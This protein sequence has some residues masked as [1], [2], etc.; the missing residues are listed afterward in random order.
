MPLYD[1]DMVN[2]L[3]PD[4][5]AVSMPSGLAGMFPGLAPAPAIPD[6]AGP[7]GA[8]ADQAA[9]PAPDVP[10]LALPPPPAPPAGAPA[11]P[12]GPQEGP[13]TDPSQLATP[14][15]PARPQGPVTTPAEDTGTPRQPA[16]APVPTNQQ[17]AKN[18]AGRAVQES[19]RASDEERAGVI[20][21]ARVQAD[22][23]TREGARLAQRDA[24]TDR[25]LQERA[26]QAAANEAELNARIQARDQLADQI[27]KTRIDRSVDHPIWSQIGLV[28]SM[29]GTA[30]TR[31]PGEAF[32]DPAYNTLM[33]LIDRKVQGQVQDLD[34]KRQALA[35]M[36]VGVQEQRQHNLDRLTE[37][38]ARRDAAL[39]QAKQAV[40]TIAT[41]MKAPAAIAGAQQ[42][43]GK[44]DQERAKLHAEFGQKAQDQINVDA[45]RS[46][47]LQMHRETLGMQY[48]I[49]SETMAANERDKMAALAE[50]LMEKGD[51]KAAQRAKD[52][53]ER[54]VWDPRTADVQLNPTGQAK[55]QQA[56]QYEAA[57][58]QAQDPQQA[59]KLRQAASDLRDSARLND[60]VL[61]PDKATAEKVR[62]QL[63]AAQ[64]MIDQ[65]SEASKVLEAGPS[66]FNREAWAGLKTTLGDLA[67]NYAVMAGEKVT[68]KGIENAME[69]IVS[70][71]P[72]SWYHREVNKGKALAALASLKNIVRQ[73]AD[74]TLKGNGIKSNWLPVPKGEGENAT[75][76]DLSEK[77]ASE[78]G[79]DETLGY[80][81]HL[82][83]GVLGAGEAEER[84][85]NE[86]H[87]AAAM[88]PGAEAGLPPRAVTHIK[89]LAAKASTAGDSAYG[90]IVNSLSNVVAD[91]LRDDSRVPA[92]LGVIDV[93]GSAN[94]ALRDA[95]IAALPDMARERVRRLESARRPVTNVPRVPSK[96]DPDEAAA[97]ADAAAQAGRDTTQRY[98]DR[99]GRGATR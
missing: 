4:G 30:M 67:K 17:L 9:P 54:A 65:I 55:M 27:A 2:L 79:E 68:V 7:A 59:A 84:L 96:F 18:Y 61:A 3:T 63:Q 44:L 20:A 81:G 80:L 26:K 16:P 5:R 1:G 74:R 22:E 40:E 50:R 76:L 15:G 82:Q 42:L 89:A 88:A 77:T 93:L 11:A 58:R 83:A 41:Q 94:P 49:H 64:G 70:F 6:V 53:A 75:R 78:R 56:D 47:A 8:S 57:A 33:Q 90:E 29:L 62:P 25:L 99:A 71:D 43:L 39:Q 37:I 23:A 24:E 97:E 72:D 48:R 73:Q 46:Q 36:N 32:N 51:A 35:Q 38:D 69:N 19:D 21:S 13:I 95:V 92:S 14:T 98:A 12:Q 31:R 91:G 85:K 86:A 87:D 52:V 34:Q 45:A 66:A 28:I 10:N 60:G